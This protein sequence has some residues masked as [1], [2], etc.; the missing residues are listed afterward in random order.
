MFASYAPAA[1]IAPDAIRHVISFC[2]HTPVSVAVARR[3]CKNWNASLSQFALTI[4]G[5]LGAVDVGHALTPLRFNAAQ[6]ACI[7]RT[8]DQTL[9]VRTTQLSG[10]VTQRLI[11]HVM[12]N[13][14]AMDAL[15]ISAIQP[16]T[17]EASAWADLALS[18]QFVV[19][20]AEP[21][22]L[23]HTRAARRPRTSLAI[24]GGVGTDEG[25]MGR[26]LAA[27]HGLKT[28]NLRSAIGMNDA[29]VECIIE[30][31]K[32][33]ETIQIE[34]STHNVNATTMVRMIGA[35]PGLRVIELSRCHYVDD[36]VIIEIARICKGIERVAIDVNNRITDESM[37][38]LATQCTNLKS[39]SVDHCPRITTAPIVLIARNSPGLTELTMNSFT[40]SRG[41]DAAIAEIAESAPG[42]TKIGLSQAYWLSDEGLCAIAHACKNLRELDVTLCDTF[43]DRGLIEVVQCCTALTSLSTAYCRQLTSSS[44]KAIGQHC[45]LLHTLDISCCQKIG[46]FALDAV[47]HGCPK[48][49]EL[50]INQCKRISD[51]PVLR[52]ARACTELRVLSAMHCDALTDASILAVAHNCPQLV[53]INISGCTGLTDRAFEALANCKLLTDISAW[54]CYISAHVETDL[55]R[56]LPELRHMQYMRGHERRVQRR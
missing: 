49:R 35:F 21:S 12:C 11:D 52:I 47:A 7:R 32:A 45:P 37:T 13:C 3:V 22:D 27:A 10:S 25:T 46:D 39:I 42:L 41:F 18:G 48:L 24:C 38:E 55:W 2:T 34:G 8:I 17:L 14:P 31:C 51:G 36:S 19:T 9:G 50:R 23:T 43:T 29:S 30:N 6:R 15:D 40:G 28:L 16:I 1:H 44:I 20:L 56:K 53:V 26:A 5:G 33:L 54:H 4:S